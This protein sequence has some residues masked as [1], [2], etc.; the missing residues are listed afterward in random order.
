MPP[1]ICWLEIAYRHVCMFARPPFAFFLDPSR[2]PACVRSL[3]LPDLFGLA[4]VVQRK[5]DVR[6]LAD[7]VISK[8]LQIDEKVV[9]H[10]DTA[11]V[12]MAL[13]HAVT[14]GTNKK[15]TAKETGPHCERGRIASI[16]RNCARAGSQM[17]E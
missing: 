6:I 4:S 5:E 9:R 13:S 15:V 17:S 12:T 7:A 8:T 3:C 1:S 14:L 16:Y 11:T 2:Q 10:G